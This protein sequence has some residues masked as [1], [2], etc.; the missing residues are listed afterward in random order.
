MLKHLEDWFLELDPSEEHDPENYFSSSPEYSSEIYAKAKDGETVQ[1]AYIPLV[2]TASDHKAIGELE[3][4]ER[5]ALDIFWH[6][7]RHWWEKMFPGISHPRYK[8]IFKQYDATEQ[9][10]KP[11][12]SKELHDAHLHLVL[13]APYMYELL[14]KYQKTGQIDASEVKKVLNIVKGVETPHIIRIP[15]WKSRAITKED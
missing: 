15:K 14:S 3:T 1:V 13:S 5:E 7:K 12:H 6:R 8:P 2:L 11:R 9:V 4:K 10:Y